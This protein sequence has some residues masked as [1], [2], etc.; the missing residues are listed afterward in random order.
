MCVSS[1]RG[2]RATLPRPGRVRGETWRGASDRS[3]EPDGSM[4]SGSGERRD[5]LHR[6]PDAK[7]RGATNA[8]LIPTAPVEEL[9]NGPCDRQRVHNS[10]RTRES[11]TEAAPKR[12]LLDR[13][14]REIAAPATAIS[15]AAGQP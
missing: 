7:D 4:M 1:T 12:A 10:R 14:T 11:E 15:P 5:A 8:A 6:A 2:D 3:G 9:P 13:R